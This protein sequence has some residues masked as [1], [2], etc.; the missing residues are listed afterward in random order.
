MIAAKYSL[1]ETRKQAE[2]ETKLGNFD[3]RRDR[4]WFWVSSYW[5]EYLFMLMPAKTTQMTANTAEVRANA[6]TPHSLKRACQQPLVIH[7]L[8][9]RSSVPTKI[10]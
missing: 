2:D 9:P 7:W 3:R 10:G 6:G 4:H 5:R 8:S 1:A